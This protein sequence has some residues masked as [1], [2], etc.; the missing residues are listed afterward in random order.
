MLRNYSVPSITVEH[1]TVRR[2][3]DKLMM[4][5]VILLEA[6]RPT[7]AKPYSRPSHRLREIERVIKSRHGFGVPHTDDASAYVEA[8]AYAYNAN[9]PSITEKAVKAWCLTW[10]PWALNDGSMDAAL[11]GV[12]SRKYDLCRY[13]VGKLLA[14]RWSEREALNL[15]TIA[16]YDVTPERQKELARE[17]KKEVDRLR[18]EAKRRAKGVKSRAE[19]EANSVNSQKPW[20]AEGISKRTWYR[21]QKSNGTG[22]SRAGINKVCDTLV[23]NDKLN[24]AK[25][26]G[27]G[28]LVP[29]E[30]L[31]GSAGEAM[32][33]RHYAGL[34]SK[35]I[36]E[37]KDIRTPSFNQNTETRRASQW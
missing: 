23:P 13:A 21:R 18:I 33:P 35:T 22:P 17:K 10:A 20:I 19:Y 3:G 31:H 34:V 9:D 6:R 26:L 37:G 8:I 1:D 14:V 27:F 29:R 4:G 15:N 16:A 25:H 7:G 30:R 11:A 28:G 5:N 36:A 24:D 2:D 32:K 12:V